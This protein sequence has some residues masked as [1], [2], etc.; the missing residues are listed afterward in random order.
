MAHTVLLMGGKPIGS[1]EIARYVKGRGDRLVVTDY[2]DPSDSPA[3][4]IADEAWDVST[5]DV[6]ELAHRCREEGVD[7]VMTGVHEFNIERTIELTEALGLPCWCDR[8]QWDSFEDKPTFKRLCRGY[9]I[10]VAR[11]YDPDDPGSVEF[12]VVVKPADGSGSRGF[13]KCLSL[14]ELDGAVA[15]AREFSPTGTALVEEL[16][17]GEAA[18]VHYTVHGGRAHFSGM[19]DKHS[20]RMGEKGAP[21][22]AL[23]VAPS[24]HQAQ[25]LAEVD[26]KARALVESLGLRESVLW[27][28]AF[29]RDG[30]FVFNEAGLRFGGSMTNYMVR[31]LCGIDQMALMYAC[32][33]REPYD[34]GEPE[35]R[36]DVRYAVFPMHLR[37]GTV[38]SIDGLNALEADPNFVAYVPVHGQ[39]DEISDWG[40]AQQVLAYL[41][42]SA[43]DAAGLVTSM[44]RAM[45][46]LSVKGEDGAKM[47]TSL[48]D[49]GDEDAYP[50]FLKNDLDDGTRR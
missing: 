50:D 21:I 28:E 25:Y 49:P 19:A 9:G 43:P 4:R 29:Y 38:A 13:S 30:E 34:I 7:A 48:F 2:L 39:G 37:P 27:I 3:K 45:S 46:V 20:E 26:A 12:P 36:D 23:Q 35:L 17:Q 33:A 15:R 11:E 32:A 5:A 44:R 6:G 47:L 8:A 18:I 10:A 42:F 22:M 41:H 14:E 31:E 1:T 40:S 24:V 16:V